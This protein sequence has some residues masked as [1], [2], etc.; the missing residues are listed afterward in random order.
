MA[1]TR[2]ETLTDLR[3]KMNGYVEALFDLYSKARGGVR[4]HIDLARRKRVTENGSN[5]KSGEI[6]ADS[7]AECP[8]DGCARLARLIILEI[9]PFNYFVGLHPNRI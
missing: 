4:N 3:R 2:G 7:S 1:T 9:N 5:A 6:R 8:T